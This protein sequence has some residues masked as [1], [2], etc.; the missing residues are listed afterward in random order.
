MTHKE[1]VRSLQVRYCNTVESLFKED[2]IIEFKTPFTV[3]LSVTNTYDDSLVKDCYIVKELHDGKY[4]A[5]TSFHG[6][7]FDD[8][9]IYEVEDITEVAHILDEIQIGNF[10]I[11]QNEDN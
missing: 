2:S 6:D 7:E 11:L 4:L 9:S 1:E 3:Y 10:K 5:G 8:L